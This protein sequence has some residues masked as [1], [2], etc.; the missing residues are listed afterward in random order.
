MRGTTTTTTTRR[1]GNRIGGTI[2]A[3]AV[4]YAAMSENV[5]ECP[6]GAACRLSYLLQRST[7][8]EV[9]GERAGVAR[10]PGTFAFRVRCGGHARGCTTMHDPGPS[11]GS[12]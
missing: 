8:P 12:G 2:R 6:I 1:T 3:A 11:T 5:R 9:A 10:K 4:R 7:R